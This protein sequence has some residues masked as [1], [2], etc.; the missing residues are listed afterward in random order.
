MFEESDQ[1]LI[2]FSAGAYQGR[3][4]QLNVNIFSGK[5]EYVKGGGLTKWILCFFVILF[6]LNVKKIKYLF[7][8]CLYLATTKNVKLKNKVEKNN[9][10][11]NFYKS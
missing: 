7:N 9:I 6:H 8:F 10:I 3:V 5:K 1:C 2:H 4:K 11:T